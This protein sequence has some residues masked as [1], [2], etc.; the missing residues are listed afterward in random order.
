MQKHLGD[1]AVLVGWLGRLLALAIL[2]HLGP[3]LLH[4]LQDCIHTTQGFLLAV[5]E[6]VGGIL[7]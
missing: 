2:G 6:H 1:V 4:I 3:H 5:D 7:D